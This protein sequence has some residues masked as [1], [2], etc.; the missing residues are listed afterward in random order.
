M[1]F[2]TGPRGLR[3]AEGLSRVKIGA[4][5]FGFAPEH[6]APNRSYLEVA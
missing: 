5:A 6:D 3:K 1:I 2:L 4:I